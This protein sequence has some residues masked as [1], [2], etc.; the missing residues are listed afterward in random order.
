MF[1]VATAS[2]LIHFLGVQCPFFCF[3][4]G[5]RAFVCIVL[6]RPCFLLHGLKSKSKSIQVRLS[7]CR[8]GCVFGM[9][10]LSYPLRVVAVPLADFNKRPKA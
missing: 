6:F 10:G 4:A 3:P 5:G 2:F 1:L 9:D 7:A 8:P